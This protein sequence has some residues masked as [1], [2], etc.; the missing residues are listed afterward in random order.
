MSYFVKLFNY[1]VFFAV[2][3]TIYNLRCQL[4]NLFSS[5]VTLKL[6]SFAVEEA[7]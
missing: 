4:V 2:V 6:F 3:E 1:P 5:L 7:N